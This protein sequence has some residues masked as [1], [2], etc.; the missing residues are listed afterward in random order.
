MTVD[1]LVVP[2]TT[3]ALLDTVSFGAGLMP[4]AAVDSFFVTFF[5]STFG[6]AFIGFTL[7]GALLDSSFLLCIGLLIPTLA[8]A[9]CKTFSSFFL[10]PRD[11]LV[12]PLWAAEV[13]NDLL[14][15][16]SCMVI[17]ACLLVAFFSI[18]MAQ[19][20]VVLS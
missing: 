3:N 11:T 20:E 14:L 19:I 5:E 16:L 17:L 15:L 7:R 13:D 4:P 1:S 18:G 10:A 9:S 12:V 2:V 8:V 6:F